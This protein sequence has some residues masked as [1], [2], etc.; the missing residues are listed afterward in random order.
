MLTTI[1]LSLRQPSIPK[2][3]GSSPVSEEL[4]AHPNA[5]KLRINEHERK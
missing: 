3:V 2:E 4:R 1:E 5:V